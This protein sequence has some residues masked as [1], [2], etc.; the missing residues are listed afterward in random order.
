[1]WKYKQPN[2]FKEM[3]IQTKL[4]TPLYQIRSLEITIASREP[5]DEPVARRAA[6]EDGE[7]VINSIQAYGSDSNESELSGIEKVVVESESGAVDVYNLQGV[8][9][10]RGVD[11]GDAVA[12]LP[13]GIYIVGNQ[14]VIV[15]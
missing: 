1:M 13:A 7:Y 6:N 11:R 9:V 4:E 8:A 3:L 2:R 10:R 14:K 15:R 12:G 5:S